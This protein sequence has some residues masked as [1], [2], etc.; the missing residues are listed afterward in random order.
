MAGTAVGM[1][2]KP[3]RGVR[4]DIIR[5]GGTPKDHR[6][7]NRRK[8]AD[9]AKQNKLKQEEENK[10]PPPLFKLKR[11][12]DV[13]AKLNTRRSMPNLKTEE[14]GPSPPASGSSRKSSSS[15]PKNF[16]NINAAKARKPPPTPPSPEPTTVERKT[17][18][19]EI[20]QY[21]INRKMK[22]AQ[23]EMERLHHLQESKI[24]PGM[25]LVSEPQR[26]ETLAALR[27]KQDALLSQ[28]AHFPVVVETTGMKHRK[29]LVEAQLKELEDLEEV[30]SRKRVLVPTP[31]VVADPT[32]PTNTTTPPIENGMAVNRTSRVLPPA[33]EKSDGGIE[34]RRRWRGVGGGGSAGG[35]VGGEDRWMERE[36]GVG[37]KMKADLNLN[38]NPNPNGN[39]CVPT[40]NYLNNPY[41]TAAPT[42]NINM[43]SNYPVFRP[44]PPTTTSAT[45]ATSAPAPQFHPP[46]PLSILPTPTTATTTAAAIH[47]TP[48]FVPPPPTV[49]FT[50]TTAIPTRRITPS[51]P[52]MTAIPTTTAPTTAAAAA[53]DFATA[54]NAV[55]LSEKNEEEEDGGMTGVAIWDRATRLANR[56]R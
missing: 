27:T 23:Q 31:A 29:A 48:P 24:P 8:L 35:A 50:S 16:I 36:R 37:G 49:P 5:A 21:L 43:S 26:L 4:D 52:H 11:F 14:G 46:A 28:L 10:P 3:S 40:Y 18:S 7:E 41:T 1:L 25:S 33:A 34:G 39:S 17:P 45:T 32:V 2:L 56:R 9:L 54:A 47:P 38:P 42:T 19:G 44:P 12:E 51:P 55:P 53:I 6:K 20:P 13:P 15:A 22:W 30:F